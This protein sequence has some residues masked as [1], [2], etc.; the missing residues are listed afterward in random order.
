M[1]REHGWDCIFL[2]P[3]HLG[4]SQGVKLIRYE[5]PKLD[6]DVAY[7]S[8][9]FANAVAQAKAVYD[10]LLSLHPT[11]EPDLI[12]GHSGIGST[13]FLAELY[14]KTPIVNYFE[15]YFRPHRNEID[16]R[17]DLPV[18]PHHALKAPVSNAMLHLDLEACSAGMT[19]M[20]FQHQLMPKAYQ[21]KIRVLHEGI[22]T[23]FWK[24][25]P[26]REI[27]ANGHRIGPETK[28]VTYVSR[29]LESTRGFD[30]FMAAARRVC[31][32]RA[33]VFFLVLGSD[34]IYYGRDQEFINAPSFREH[35]L[36]GD[37]YDL[38]R[39]LQ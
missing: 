9:S 36:A 37:D 15:Y 39:I 31:S 13:L 21:H 38:E 5:R 26:G 16:F 33:D 17:S 14:P 11:L 18:L 3:T 32:R 30:L 23:R 35:V 1:V 7:Y 8:R 27:K 29:G 22:Q 19:P 12:V 6:T 28:V 34:R 2:N 25:Q 20:P 10:C 4:V 24:R